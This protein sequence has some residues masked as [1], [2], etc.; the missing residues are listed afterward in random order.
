MIHI[1]R[2]ERPDIVH[3]IALRMVVLGARGAFRRRQKLV[4]APTGLGHVWSN[5]GPI[6]RVVRVWR[7]SSS[8]TG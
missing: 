8:D 4:L 7:V 5:D 3:C 6:E 1:V 2:A